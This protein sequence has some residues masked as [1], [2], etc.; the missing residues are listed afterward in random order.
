MP[1]NF[2]Q[3]EADI[4]CAFDAVVSPNQFNSFINIKRM[5]FFMKSAT[6][7]S[8]FILFMDCKAQTD[9]DILEKYFASIGGV[10]KWKELKSIHYTGRIINRIVEME[11][12][13]SVYQ[14]P[15]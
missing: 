7:L 4:L 11:Y 14:K 10:E 9:D 5:R 13:I 12:P 6:L 1:F 8:I 3:Q 2:P 15:K